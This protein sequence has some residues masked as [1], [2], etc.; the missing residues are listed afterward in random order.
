M[1]D[2]LSRVSLV[3]PE[4]HVLDIMQIL[5]TAQGLLAQ[6]G[7][8]SKLEVKHHVR[9]TVAVAGGTVDTVPVVPVEL[10][11]TVPAAAVVLPAGRHSVRYRVINPRI[12]VGQIPHQVRMLLLQHGP[13]TAKHLEAATGFGR[14]SIESAL[15]KLRTEGSVESVPDVGQPIVQRRFG[16][17]AV[18]MG[19]PVD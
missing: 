1:T 14:K 10:A 9:A 15:H 2:I 11:D 16:R 17:K 7:V 5:L 3:V 6:D 13:S 19:V 12:R 4:D 18:R 8:V